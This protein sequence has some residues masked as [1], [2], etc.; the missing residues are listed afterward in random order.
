MDFAPVRLSWRLS[1]LSG[2]GPADWR[3]P[4]FRRRQRVE[5]QGPTQQ[6]GIGPNAPYARH[7]ARYESRYPP[8][9]RYTAFHRIGNGGQ[10]AA[11]R[12]A[13]HRAGGRRDS[14]PRPRQRRNVPHRGHLLIE[15]VPL[16]TIGP[17]QNRVSTP[18]LPEM[19]GSKL[20]ASQPDMRPRWPVGLPR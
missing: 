16:I 6:H 18:D 5:I 20:F 10:G 13:R 17:S 19:D 3:H 15:D 2:S 7:P 14:T 1:S 4:L 11:K 8:E 9:W 12:A